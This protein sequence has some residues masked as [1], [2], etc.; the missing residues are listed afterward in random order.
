MPLSFLMVFYTVWKNYIFT[1]SEY[2]YG[3]STVALKLKKK[4]PWRIHSFELLLHAHPKNKR[5]NKKTHYHKRIKAQ[6]P[7]GSNLSLPLSPNHPTPPP[8]LIQTIKS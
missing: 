7:I 4:K 8:I 6:N 5:K 3:R 2:S 1:K